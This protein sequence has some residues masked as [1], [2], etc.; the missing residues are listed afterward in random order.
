MDFHTSEEQNTI[1]DLARGI[2]EQEL[3]RDRLKAAATTADGIDVALWKTLAEANL[4]GVAV[5]E[6]QGGM[7][8]GILEV[9]TL[10]EEIG[11]SVAPLPVLASLVLGGLPIARFGTDA[12]RDRWLRA[13]ASGDAILSAA[14]VDAGSDDVA[15]PATR[16]RRDGDAW[17]LDGAKHLVPAAGCAA[18]VL[19]PAATDA[20]VAIF[21]VDPSAAGV[22]LTAQRTSTREPLFAM[23]LAGVR[24][25]DEDLLGADAQNADVAARWIHDVALAALCAMQVGVSERALEITAGHLKERTQFGVP[26]GSFQSVQHRAA[27]CWIDLQA[28][29]WTAWRAACRLAEEQDATRETAVAKFWAAEGGSR[30]ASAA[31]HLHGG[32]GVDVDYAVHRYFLWTKAIELTLGSATPHL[33]RL[34]RELAKT[35]PQE[36]V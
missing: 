12:Q 14:L 22:A 2:L 16:A 35:G 4:L 32:L 36:L 31:Q 8:L 20:G 27:D 21:L 9:C 25:A 6:A 33:V 17:I 34:G 28:M 26:I 7:G 3:S 10:L 1:R 23:Q 24:V 30:I 15:R 13:L 5:P 19:V 11:R 29:R 18:R